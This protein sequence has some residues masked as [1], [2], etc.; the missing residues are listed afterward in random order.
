MKW[1]FD[2]IP[3][4]SGRIALITGANSG[5]GFQTSLMLA[6]KGAEVVL[7]CRNLTKAK[8]A[9]DL[10]RKNYPPAK[11]S[12]TKLDLS[13]LNSVADCAESF[14][15]KYDRLDLLINNA[16]VMVPPLSYTKQ[17][18]ELQFGTNHL[19]HFALTGRLLPL[20]SR[21]DGSRVVSLSS[22]GAKIGRIDFNDLQYENKHYSAWLAY[23]QSKLANLMFSLE[24]AR[25][26]KSYDLKTIAVAAHPGGSATNLQRT[27]SFFMKRIL[28]PLISHKPAQAALPTLRA[29]CDPQAANGSFW[30]PSGFFELTGLPEEANVPKQARDLA[31]STRLWEESEKLTSIKFDFISM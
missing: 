31:I 25:R 17:G 18:Y 6:K 15:K 11:V 12:I 13:D 5:L 16:G 14:K 10:I 3:D 9:L 21:R 27:S 4:Q 7:A 2:N 29:A 1:T 30:G 26:L 23:G 19:G 8:D 24:L 20:M 28:T 22:L